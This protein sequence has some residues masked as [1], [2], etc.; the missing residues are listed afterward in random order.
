MAGSEDFEQLVAAA[1]PPA[2]W[3]EVTVLI[4]VS[5]G[6]DSVAL[7]RVLARLKRGGTGRLL[8][9]HFNHALREAEATADEQFVFEL[10]RHLAI[11]CHVG[12][13]PG[14]GLQMRGD[15]LE[16]AA[17]E[18][19]YQFLQAT[20]EAAGARYVVTAHTADDQAETILHRVLRGTG[21]AGLAGIPRARPLGPA[22]CLLRPLL[23]IRRAQIEAYLAA[24]RQSYRTDSTNHALELT[25]NRVRRQLLPLLAEQFNPA[26][27]AAL[28]RLGKL[29][30]EAQDAIDDQAEALLDAALV[31]RSETSIVLDCERL[32]GMRRHLIREVLVLAWQGQA[33]PLQAM[34]FN[35][36][37]ELASLVLAGANGVGQTPRKKVFPADVAAAREGTQLSL[38]RKTTP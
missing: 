18:A 22:V 33:W 21:V 2:V 5:G 6:A 4:A 25:R 23:E 35:Q 27:V 15:G 32:A 26:I 24:L 10:C 9:A 8:V 37:D 16:A 30:A 11:D 20:A 17:R 38:V 28:V 1:W 34:G 14:G 12:R 29:A 19:R 36:W 13:A 7:L 31:S 3:Q